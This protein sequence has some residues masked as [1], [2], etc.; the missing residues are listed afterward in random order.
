MKCK[1]ILAGD[2][3]VGK[4]SLINR[5]VTGSFTGDYKA[6]IGVAISSKRV[7]TDDHKVALQIWDIAGQT[8]FRQF[9]KKF[10]TKAKGA[11]LVFDLTVPKSLD[12]LHLWIE[13][14]V[15]ITGEIPFVLIGNKADLAEL[16]AVSSEDINNFLKDQLEVAA[17]FNTSALAGTNVEHAFNG[18][19]TQILKE[20]PMESF[21]IN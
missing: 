17:Y 18:L 8:L 20:N 4:T 2:G 15:E 3:A 10:Y 6:T 5:F 16:R 9:R 14:I 21:D 11:L 12:N 1:I 7:N 19:V 13:D